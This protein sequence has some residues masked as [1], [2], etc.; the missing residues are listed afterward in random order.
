[1]WQGV[2]RGVLVAGVLVLLG[3]FLGDVHPLGDSLAVFQP[4]IVLGL[5]MVGILLRGS[6]LGRLGIGLALAVGVAHGAALVNLGGA[7]EDVDVTLY[8]KNLL[9][10]DRDRSAF[11]TDV[12]QVSADLVTMQE[13]SRANLPVLA[14][15]SD[16]YPHQVVCEGHAVGAVAILSKTPLEGEDCGTGPGFARAVTRIGGRDVQVYALHLH[17][18]WPRAQ[19]DHVDQL[20][21]AMQAAPTGVTV[22]GGDFNMV[23]RGRSLAAIE[24]ATGT[25]RVGRLVRTFTLFGYPLGIDHVLATGGRGTVEV[26]PQLGSDHYGVVARIAFTAP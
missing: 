3:S 23:A 13:V 4:V 9:Y 24:R 15:L 19:G 26:R 14:A 25:A 6:A 10:R 20:L 11:L 22:V 12:R 21:P 16:V 1:M 2:A 18:P 7:V 8:Q 17:W 5:L